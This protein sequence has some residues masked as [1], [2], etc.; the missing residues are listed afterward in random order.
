MKHTLKICLSLWAVLVAGSCKIVDDIPYP[1]V[2]S[3]ITAFEVEGQCDESGE[4]T[5]I[6]TI[7]NSAK[8]VSLFVDDRVNLSKIKITRME[9]SNDATI[10]PDKQACLSAASF[11]QKSF[12]TLSDGDDS[13][14]D[15]SSPVSFTLH[16]YQDYV[17]TVSVNQLVKREVEVEDQIGDAVVDPSSR[18]VVIYVSE[19]AKL[20]ALKVSK[21]SLGGQHG[22]VEPDPTESKTYDFSSECKFQVKE[23]WETESHAW[24]VFVYETAEQVLP[25]ASAS[26]ASNGA[27]IISGQRPNG[28]MP[29][30]RYKE[31][32]SADWITV[33]DI[34]IQL[35]TATTYQVELTSLKSDVK[36]LYTVSFGAE[37]LGQQEF[38]FTGEQLRDADFNSWSKA[39]KV[40]Q[41]WAEGTVSYWD[42]GNKGATTVGDSNSTPTEDSSDGSGFSANLLSKYIVIKFAAGNIFTGTYIETD[43]TNGVLGWG[44]PFSSRPSKL[45]FDY[46]YH[47][48]KINKV[49]DSSLDHLKGR[50]D[51]CNVYIA[52]ADW[53]E[54]VY[55][56]RVS[57]YK[58][59]KF[60]FIVRTRP[61]ERQLLD[62]N[63]PHVIAYGSL[64]KGEDVPNWTKASIKLDYRSE[65]TPKWIVV[66]ATSSKYGD[67]FTGGDGSLLNVDNFKL[68]YE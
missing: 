6:A 41:P 24:R 8:S 23:A 20:N 42:T 52:L 64:S 21:F 46:K 4:G 43:G 47:S 48:E 57:E 60:P 63:D 2:E 22:S 27:T 58:G 26:S 3:A 65:R 5:G 14:V 13:R 30:V 7:D 34:L 44:R 18:T 38:Y 68:V 51:S 19:K 35:P 16:T 29:T 15:F 17:W 62:P 59:Q 66:V 32:S 11:P 49:G 1:V 53:D 37:S 45:T 67:Y 56:G 55:N 61:S 54:E 36:Y 39:G 28:V 31:T 40:F 12:R 50:P 25:T 9:V 10:T 33:P